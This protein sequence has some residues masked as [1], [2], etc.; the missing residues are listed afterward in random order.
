MVAEKRGIKILYIQSKDCEENAVQLDALPDVIKRIS[1]VLQ[2]T[3]TDGFRISFDILSASNCHVAEN[4][5]Q[6]LIDYTNKKF[7]AE[8][9]TWIESR[10]RILEQLFI[11]DNKISIPT[12]LL[13]YDEIAK[14]LLIGVLYVTR[15]KITMPIILDDSLSYVIN[16]S[17]VRAFLAM[18][19]PY[20]RML[21]RYPRTE[22]MLEHNPIILTPGGNAGFF[23][24]AN[25]EKYVVIFD[26]KRWEINRRDVEK[27]VYSS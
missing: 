3:A 27:I 14:R 9:A 20:I 13:P 11:V 23:R 26:D 18:M 2:F 21:N 4:P 17:Y 24:L 25:P 19:R 22:E 1:S 15:S 6:C 12:C 16:E 8:I 10:L 5:I 7:K